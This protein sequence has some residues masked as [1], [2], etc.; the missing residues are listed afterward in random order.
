MYA[1][2]SYYALVDAAP[3]LLNVVDPLDLHVE[4]L[5]AVLG[6]ARLGLLQNRGEDLFAADDLVPRNLDPLDL[7]AFG[8]SGLGDVIAA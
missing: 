8:D 4:Q 3:H 1:I 2:R 5:D 6:G 7:E